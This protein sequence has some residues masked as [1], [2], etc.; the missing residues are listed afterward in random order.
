MVHLPLFP[1]TFAL[2]VLFLG[3][4]AI[5]SRF[6]SSCAF[7]YAGAFSHGLNLCTICFRL[8]VISF[9]A[10]ACVRGMPF[11]I[12]YACPSSPCSLRCLTDSC[13]KLA[14]HSKHV[15]TCLVMLLRQ[16]TGFGVAGVTTAT[17]P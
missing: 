2:A 14:P 3:A 4:T 11:L 7:T 1:D 10:R 9:A 12:R 17:L 8:D 16:S 5:F 13:L 15:T 6:F